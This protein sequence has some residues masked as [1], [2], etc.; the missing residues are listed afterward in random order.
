[1]SQN[2][3]EYRMALILI[4]SVGDGTILGMWKMD[5]GVSEL[6]LTYPFLSNIDIAEI[7]SEKRKLEILSVNAL[8]VSMTGYEGVCL[9]HG[10]DGAPCLEGYHISIS[11]TRG[12]AAIILS[13]NYCVGID[14]EYASDR[15]GR[16]KAKFIRPDEDFNDIQSLLVNWSAKETVY[17]LRHSEKLDYFDMR[18]HQFLSGAKGMVMV[19]DLKKGDFVEVNY[20]RTDEYVVTYSVEYC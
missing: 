2:L 10:D 9:R 5:E 12:Y 20:R 11:H 3:A 6:L 13:R 8:L 16:I 14:V 17:K 1:M 7:K 15:V 4:E 18:L 19:D